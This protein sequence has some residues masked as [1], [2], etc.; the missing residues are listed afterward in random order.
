MTL[1]PP[2]S[3]FV[4][5]KASDLREYQLP[6]NK[7]KDYLGNKSLECPLVTKRQLQSV[8]HIR[9]FIIYYTLSSNMNSC[10][11]DHITSKASRPEDWW[12]KIKYQVSVKRAHYGC[13]RLPAVFAR[14]LNSKKKG[15]QSLFSPES[16]TLSSCW[17]IS[18]C[19][20]WESQLSCL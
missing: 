14:S 7:F 13:C 18:Q 19:K 16:L 10:A 12:V 11:V 6:A 15:S 20:K 2:L 8:F 5:F 9:S 17:S 3:T 1:S 4:N